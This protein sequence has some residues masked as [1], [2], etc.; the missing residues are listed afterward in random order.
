MP[1][2]CGTGSEVTNIAILALNSRGTKKGLAVDEMYADSAVLVPELLNG[3]PFRFFATRLH[4]CP[5]PCGGIQP[6]P[7]G[8][9]DDPD[10]WLQGH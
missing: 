2:T 9:R 10:V 8:Q 5:D 7:Q 6:F 1:T 4:R 3:L